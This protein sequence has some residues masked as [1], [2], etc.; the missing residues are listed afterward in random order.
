MQ[1]LF[2][3]AATGAHS[4][5][6][7]SQGQISNL[8]NIKPT[9]RRIILEEAAGITG[10]HTRRREA[11]LRLKAAE[12]NLDRLNDIIETLKSQLSNIKKQSRQATRYKNIASQI[13]LSEAIISFYRIEEV[14]DEQKKAQISLKDSQKRLIQLTKESTESSTLVSNYSNKIP[15][16]RR[17]QSIDSESL[18]KLK[19][20]LDMID[21]ENTRVTNESK[22]ISELSYQ[23]Q[24]DINRENRNIA[25]SNSNLN[26][27]KNEYKN[28]KEKEL[29]DY[30]D[31]DSSVIKLQK[32]KKKHSHAERLHEDSQKSLNIFETQKFSYLSKIDEIKENL[33][34]LASKEKDLKVEERQLLL[35]NKNFTHL[36]ILDKRIEESLEKI[37]KHERIYSQHESEYSDLNL[38]LTQTH[39]SLQD[40]LVLLASKNN[41]VLRIEAEIDALQ[42]LTKTSKEHSLRNK[43]KVTNGY[44]SAL[45]AAIGSDLE[46]SEL[47]KKP[48]YWSYIKFNSLPSLPKNIEPL[49]KFV[50]SPKVLTARL[51]QI[52]ITH[53]K[54]GPKLQKLLLPGQK[55]VSKS[56]AM[57]R[58]DG[59][60]YSTEAETT[61]KRRTLAHLKLSELNK[62]LS[63]AIQEKDEKDKSVN[64]LKEKLNKSQNNLNKIS[65]NTNNYKNLITKLRNE[66]NTYRDKL[67]E[68]HSK[69]N[70]QI[71][72]VKVIKNSLET[73]L[74]DKESNKSSLIMA[75]KELKK[76]DD[77]K[78]LKKKTL[79]LKNS[80]SQARIELE[81]AIA[82][83]SID[84]ETSVSIKSRIDVISNQINTW[85]SKYNESQKHIKTLLNRLTLLK[86]KLSELD[87][88]PDDLNSKREVILNQ[89]DD[90]VKKLNQ[91]NDNLIQ[92]ERTLNVS[93]SK[94]KNI[95][96]E[97]SLAREEK[98]RCET[99]EKQSYERII[100]EKERLKEKLNC[101]PHELHEIIG[102]N[103]L[104]LMPEKESIEIKLER[105]FRERE[106][107]GSVNLR[108]EEEAKEITSKISELELEHKE[109][110]LAV[111]HLNQGIIN[112]N[113]QAK[114]QLKN[115]FEKVNN[116][117]L[118]LFK[119][120]FGGG[121]GHLELI[122]KEDPLNSGLELMVSPPGKKLQKL[123]LL[124]GGEQ[125]LTALALVFSV[126][127][128]R[129]S[130]ICV[131]DEVDAP[132][133][134]NNVNRFCDLLENMSQNNDTKFLVI[135]HNSHTMARMNRLYGATML[136]PGVSK[137]VSVDLEQAIELRVA[138]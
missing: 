133:D 119:K 18:Q 90:A 3:D 77:T 122:D 118:K 104:S 45:A 1:T 60:T 25:D 57:W 29:K 132:L 36:S 55:L 15:I 138:E 12:T 39:N 127:L 49:S 88:K 115:A 135:T 31:L 114:N 40:A 79:S 11:E 21:I 27:L 116:N 32:V 8:I 108:A 65:Q 38:S 34:K 75:E 110:L 106:R 64:L 85:K 78:L 117:F 5:T 103:D 101:Q 23:I 28:L 121:H 98:A 124:S 14:K 68:E 48:I 2:A 41:L 94:E 26:E 86:D 102:I 91:S 56:G 74:V 16:L 24:E 42:A 134:D 100:I 44:E 62:Q 99:M 7:V 83:Y 113:K 131:L 87:K 22:N 17:Q 54:E 107:L 130:P 46:A 129:P 105:L 71:T 111:G 4:N 33:L 125:A 47:E 73:I 50:K 84:T 97:V 120:L 76:L 59:L 66:Y 19:T 6:I 95:Q 126:F 9:E 82:K 69:N 35:K 128:A 30:A 96:E 52:G 89:L 92:T 13:R 10:I 67:A 43:I 112:L 109:L 61:E 53:E 37:Q 136:E 20:A 137:L 80:E 63:S 70:E 93:E 58:W 51:S 81:E 123:S 72:R